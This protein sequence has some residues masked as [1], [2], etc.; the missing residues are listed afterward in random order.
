MIEWLK[1]NWYWLALP[2][3]GLAGWAGWRWF[4]RAGLSRGSGASL[5]SF[6]PER[7]KQER[8]RVK[9]ARDAKVKENKERFDAL[10]K[11][12]NDKFKD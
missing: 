2:L 4:S 3:L 12:I 6:D 10:R 7:A 9:A 5:P 1:A 8:E 11:E